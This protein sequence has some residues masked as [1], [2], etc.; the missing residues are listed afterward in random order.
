M[1]KLE[2]QVREA[3]VVTL[4]AA[5]GTGYVLSHF[6][7]L[8]ILGGTIRAGIHVAKPTL[9]VLGA[10]KISEYLKETRSED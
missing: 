6:P 9:L 3:P 7:L 5:M 1:R 10:M 2:E 4:A 8:R